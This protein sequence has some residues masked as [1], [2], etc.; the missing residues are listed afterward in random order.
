M[1]PEVDGFQFLDSLRS[2]PELR[3]LPV[4]VV[5]AKMLTNEERARLMSSAQRLIEKNAHTRQQ[6]LRLIGEQVSSMLHRPSMA[7]R[8]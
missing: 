1:M 5:T 6:L 4:M 7:P 8:L 3:G 2:Q